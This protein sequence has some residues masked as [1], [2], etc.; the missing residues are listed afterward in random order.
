MGRVT[1]EVYTG[2]ELWD[3]PKLAQVRADLKA[4]QAE[5]LLVYAIDRLSRDPIHLAIVA[6]ECR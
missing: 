2:A 5:A 6:E 3:R 4:G 1:R